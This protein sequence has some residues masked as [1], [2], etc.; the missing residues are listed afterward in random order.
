MRF[1]SSTTFLLLVLFS[2]NAALGETL[3]FSC[4]D[5]EWAHH[6]AKVAATSPVAHSNASEFPYLSIA[7]DYMEGPLGALIMYGAFLSAL[8][9]LAKV[10]RARKIRHL[11]CGIA[12]ILLAAASFVVRSFLATF[13]NDECIVSG[14]LVNTP[15]GT[16]TI[17]EILVGERLLS[18]DNSGSIVESRVK[19][20][21]VHSAPNHLRIR[22]ASGRELLVTHPHLVS[23]EQGWAPACSLRP[24]DKLRALEALDTITDISKIDGTVKVHEIETYPVHNFFVAGLLVHNVKE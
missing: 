14:S 19:A 3:N 16:K 4:Q 8:F 10:Y 7:L 2:A 20:K 5:A 17:D 18:R 15:N 13:Y 1:A 6:I 23:T 24:G 12:F 9:C 11:L 22:M 21:K